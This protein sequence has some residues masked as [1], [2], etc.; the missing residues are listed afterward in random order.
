M[1]IEI[2]HPGKQETPVHVYQ[3]DLE[4]FLYVLIWICT[5]Y[6]R[7]GVLRKDTKGLTIMLWNDSTIQK[8][9]LGAS[10]HGHLLSPELIFVGFSPYFKAFCPLVEALMEVLFTTPDYRTSKSTVTHEAFI[11]IFKKALSELPPE[12]N[13][14]PP[15]TRAAATKKRA[16]IFEDKDGDLMLG[17]EPTIRK[18]STT[19]KRIRVAA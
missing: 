17:S 7:P 9:Q 3:H 13:V 10:K 14:P 1:A 11:S 18:S 6:E 8:A 16:R 4:S 15:P 12:P 2:L 19:L 5:T